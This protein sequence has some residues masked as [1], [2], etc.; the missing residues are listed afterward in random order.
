M[1]FYIG[2]SL[3][4]ANQVRSLCEYL[5]VESDGEAECTFKWFDIGDTE[6]AW[7]E[8]RRREVSELEIEG[9]RDAD[10]VILILPGGRGTHAE[11][12]A[13]LACGKPVLL[14]SETEP[15]FSLFYHHALARKCVGN[16][17][18]RLEAAIAFVK[19][20]P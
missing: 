15:K 10:R 4:D 7:T 6:P 16:F 1:K 13:A 2:A 12:G 19:E 18:A 11:L 8:E 14:L 17:W 3:S 9:V 5:E 20:A